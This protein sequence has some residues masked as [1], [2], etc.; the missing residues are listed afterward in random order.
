M[1]TSSSWSGTGESNR[2][3]LWS[4][5]ESIGRKSN[6]LD[7]EPDRALLLEIESGRSGVVL[8]YDTSRERV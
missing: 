2:C 8:I 5:H 3:D 4:I 6:H 1:P 7:T